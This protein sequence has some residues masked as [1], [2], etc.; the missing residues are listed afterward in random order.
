MDPRNIQVQ[1][2]VG[3]GVQGQE[4]RNE[5]LLKRVSVSAR[6]LARSVFGSIHRC[7]CKELRVEQLARKEC[8]FLGTSFLFITGT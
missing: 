3:L 2:D 7:C 5:L 4:L 6:I 8:D 1:S